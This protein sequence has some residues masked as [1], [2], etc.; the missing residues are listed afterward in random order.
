VA[1]KQAKHHEDVS[2]H[3]VASK[4]V[5]K[6]ADTTKQT[7]RPQRPT[8]INPQRENKQEQGKEI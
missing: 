5:T 4:Q 7:S 3:M 2:L 8:S 6:G 1:S